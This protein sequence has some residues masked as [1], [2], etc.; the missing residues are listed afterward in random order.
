[1]SLLEIQREKKQMSMLRL[2]VCISFLGPVGFR[3]SYKRFWCHKTLITIMEFGSGPAESPA[4]SVLCACVTPKWKQ[5]R[6][7]GNL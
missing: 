2:N 6:L 7:H 5:G 3:S 1:M 4:L